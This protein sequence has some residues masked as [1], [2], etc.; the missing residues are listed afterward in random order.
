MSSR[1]RTAALERTAEPAL[2]L[3]IRGRRGGSSRFAQGE[4]AATVA[5]WRWSQCSRDRP[6]RDRSWT[7]RSRLRA[8]H[9]L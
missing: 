5:Q 9:G 6:N 2:H 4:R 8:P 1:S 3:A 7:D